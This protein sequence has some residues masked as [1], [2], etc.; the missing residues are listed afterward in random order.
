[1]HHILAVNALN[2]LRALCAVRSHTFIKEI[3]DSCVLRT[4]KSKTSCRAPIHLNVQHIFACLVGILN[5]EQIFV[6]LVVMKHIFVSSYH[7]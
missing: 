7:F 4:L 3:L 2:M 1:M 5:V 6:C